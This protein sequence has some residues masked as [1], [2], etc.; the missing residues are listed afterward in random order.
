MP[1]NEATSSGRFIIDLPDSDAAIALSGIGQTTLHKLEALT[2]VSLVMRGL[3][4]EIKGRSS[5]LERAS[6]LIELMRPI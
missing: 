6:A 2:G 3:Q 5:Q 4:L 1:M